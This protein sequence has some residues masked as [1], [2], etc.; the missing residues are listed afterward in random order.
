MGSGGI[1]SPFLTWV[2]DGGEW[3][4]SRPGRYPGPSDTVDDCKYKNYSG[5][6]K[7]FGE[8]GVRL[9]IS[10]ML[11]MRSITLFCLIDLLGKR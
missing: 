10:I 5:R 6:R 3:S 7:Y 1:A 8:A 4:A 2:V 9:C 11:L